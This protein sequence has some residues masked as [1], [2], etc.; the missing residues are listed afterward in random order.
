MCIRD[1]APAAARPPERTPGPEQIREIYDRGARELQS[2]D[3]PLVPEARPFPSDLLDLS[4]WVALGAR[5]ESVRGQ[6]A[7]PGPA[8]AGGPP[9]P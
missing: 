8:D 3:E 4:V 7:P 2:G 6:R 1:R 9:P 5:L